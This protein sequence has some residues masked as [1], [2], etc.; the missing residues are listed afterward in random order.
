MRAV[1]AVILVTSL[2]AT[3]AMAGDS[4]LGRLAPGKPAGA[5]QA[6]SVTTVG[7]AVLAGALGFGAL[8]ALQSGGAALITGGTPPA[9]AADQAALEAATLNTTK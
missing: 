3:S 6:Q 8:L 5:R 9:N 4:G 7:G 2:L 1:C